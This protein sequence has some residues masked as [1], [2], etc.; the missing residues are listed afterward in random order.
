LRLKTELDNLFR[1][2]RCTSDVHLGQGR[3]GVQAPTRPV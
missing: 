1:S 3:V 2:H